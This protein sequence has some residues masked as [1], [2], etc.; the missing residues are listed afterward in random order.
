MKVLGALS[1]R[2][3]SLAGCRKHARSRLGFDRRARLTVI[4]SAYFHITTQRQRK[5]STPDLSTKMVRLSTLASGNGPHPQVHNPSELYEVHP[6]T[7]APPS[8]V[9]NMSRALSRALGGGMGGIRGRG[10][11]SYHASPCLAAARFVP[12]A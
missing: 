10:V 5:K 4:R 8:L 3:I 6:E 2:A 7:G 1:K 9:R 12:Q 11:R